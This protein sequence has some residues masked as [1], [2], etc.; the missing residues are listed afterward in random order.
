MTTAD[1]LSEWWGQCDVGD[2]DEVLP[3]NGSP[4]RDTLQQYGAILTVSQSR[5]HQYF[6]KPATHGA[7]PRGTM[8]GIR[9]GVIHAAPETPD[10]RLLAFAVAGGL[11]RKVDNYSSSDDQYTPWT[12][13]WLLREHLRRFAEARA[14]EGR[15]AT[16]DAQLA[17]IKREY[18]DYE[19]SRSWPHGHEA[20]VFFK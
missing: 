15:L 8:V 14:C 6:L 10:F 1:V 20:S 12:L 16:A 17:R 9:G 5:M 7:L 13:G 4:L 2:R 18:R 19:P 11:R 3:A